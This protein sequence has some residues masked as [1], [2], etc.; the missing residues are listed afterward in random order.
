MK[1]LAL[2]LIVAAF[3]ACTSFVDHCVGVACPAAQICL[4]LAS[5]PKCVCDD[6]HEPTDGGCAAVGEGEGE[7]EGEGG[8]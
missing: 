8:Q 6:E 3:P 5:G 4:D 2:L 7:G 1:K